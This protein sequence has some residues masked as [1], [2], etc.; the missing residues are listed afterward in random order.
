MAKCDV[1]HLFKDGRG[2]ETASQKTKGW[3]FG[4]AGEAEPRSTFLVRDLSNVESCGE[5]FALLG[6]FSLIVILM[7]GD[8]DGADDGDGDDDGD[9]DDDDDD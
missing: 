5:F 6:Y 3:C 7:H 2:A 9:A 8:G 4:S 1:W